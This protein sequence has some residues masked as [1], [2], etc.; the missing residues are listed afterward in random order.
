MERRKRYETE[1]DEDDKNAKKIVCVC[2]CVC[3]CVRAR[4]CVC[5]CVCVCVCWGVR[6]GAGVRVGGYKGEGGGRGGVDARSHANNEPC[7]SI[8]DGYRRK[9]PVVEVLHDDHALSALGH[10][11]I[12][13]DL[14]VVPQGTG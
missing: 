3:V 12:R 13:G 9:R 5:L 10:R 1:M 4:A 7:D 2:V 11:A 14:H 6:V 8:T